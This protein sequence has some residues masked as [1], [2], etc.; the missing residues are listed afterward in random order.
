MIQPLPIFL[1]LGDTTKAVACCLEISVWL[2][3]LGLSLV[4]TFPARSFPAAASQGGLP[5]HPWPLSVLERVFAPSCIWHSVA[6]WT[7][8]LSK[9]FQV[10]IPS[11]RERNLLWKYSLCRS[12]LSSDACILFRVSSQGSAGCPSKR[13]E[14]EIRERDIEE[15]QRKD[16]GRDECDDD[17][18]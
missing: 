17:T 3:H 5:A 6:G 15:T 2:A 11:T 8:T 14:R 18:N 12:S 13:K 1:A 7:M 4:V 9:L 16:G 10:L